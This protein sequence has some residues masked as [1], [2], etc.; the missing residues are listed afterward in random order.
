MNSNPTKPPTKPKAA[1]LPGLDTMQLGG[2]TMIY[3]DSLLKAVDIDPASA[4][5]DRPFTV[6]KKEAA[7]RIGKSLPTIDRM[8]RR[9]RENAAK[10]AA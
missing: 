7:R 8:I 10:G 9:G 3:F 2:C 5:S 6:S 4:P 1:S